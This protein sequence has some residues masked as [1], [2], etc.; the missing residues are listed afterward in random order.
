MLVS[1]FVNTMVFGILMGEKREEVTLE[2]MSEKYDN[3]IFF[4]PR[5]V[6][7][8]GFS[9][10]VQVHN[11][12]Y[13]ESENGTRTFGLDWR[14]VEWGYPS[15]GIDAKKYNAELY[16]TDDTTKSIG[17]YVEIGLM[18]ELCEEHGGMDLQQTLR[19]C[20]PKQK[21]EDEEYTPMLDP[22]IIASCL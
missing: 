11:G 14:L 4:L 2:S 20:L 8:D 7:K 22:S 18:D 10:S 13:C 9:I 16:G 12:N 3:R 19:G 15:E 1:E 5:I 17:A 6:C 21:E